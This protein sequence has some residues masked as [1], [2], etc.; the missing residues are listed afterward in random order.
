MPFIKESRA[1]GELVGAGTGLRRII[2]LIQSVAP[3]EIVYMHRHADGDQILRVLSGELR[4]E[5]SGETRTCAASDIAV[6]PA[7]E[8][9][10]FAA[11]GEPAL[12]EVIGEQGCGTSFA[13]H[14]DDGALEWIEV[15]RPELPWDRAGEPT[16]IDALNERAIP[17]AAGD[18]GPRR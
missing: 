1:V 4:V 17:P 11:M 8:S 10:G 2:V 18:A 16:D 5:V 3:D 15:H 9:H 6:V 7:G 13:V 14:C 12:L